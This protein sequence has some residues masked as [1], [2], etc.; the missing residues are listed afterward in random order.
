MSLEGPGAS[1]SPT[2]R[3]NTSSSSSSSSNNNGCKAERLVPYV[4]QNCLGI[5]EELLRLDSVE[6]YRLISE[7]SSSSSNI[8]SSSSGKRPCCASAL[9]GRTYTAGWP[10][11]PFARPLHFV[12]VPLDCPQAA[13]RGCLCTPAAAA[14]LTRVSSRQPAAAAAAAPAAPESSSSSYRCD[15]CGGWRYERFY[16]CYF[17]VDAG[18]LGTGAP[19]GAPRDVGAF[20]ASV[21]GSGVVACRA[22]VD[23]RPSSAR[24]APVGAL[25]PLREKAHWQG[26]LMVSPSFAYAADPSFAPYIHLKA[27][28][29]RLQVLLECLVHPLSF[30]PWPRCIYTSE[31]HDRDL[32]DGSRLAASA[33]ATAARAA[34]AAFLNRADALV[35]QGLCPRPAAA[36]A[37]AAAADSGA[38]ALQQQQQ[39]QQQ[40]KTWKE[41]VPN[42]RANHFL[43]WRVTDTAALVP[44][45]LLLAVV[46][47]AS[48]SSNSSSRRSVAD[49]LQADLQQTLLQLLPAMERLTAFEETQQQEQTLEQQQSLLMQQR[50]QEQQEAA[51][52]THEQASQQQQHQQHQHQ[53]QH[54]QHHHHHHQQRQPIRVKV[55]TAEVS[56][57]PKADVSR[58]VS[59]GENSPGVSLNR[60]TSISSSTGSS[61]STKE[62]RAAPTSPDQ[63][64]QKSFSPPQQQQKRERAV[65]QEQQEPQHQPPL[66]PVK[67][68]PEQKQ[69]GIVHKQ[70]Q[71]QQQQQQSRGVLLIGLSDDE[72]EDTTALLRRLQT[73][74]PPQLDERQ[75][76]RQQQQQSQVSNQKEKRESAQPQQ[77]QQEVLLSLEEQIL[78]KERRLQELQR[79]LQQ[80]EEQ[81]LLQAKQQQQQQRRE[82]TQQKRQRCLSSS[83]SDPDSSSSELGSKKTHKRRKGSLGRPLQRSSSSGSKRRG[84]SSDSSSDSE[85]GDRSPSKEEVA[86]I[87]FLSC[88]VSSCDTKRIDQKLQ[89]LAAKV[90]PCGL[91]QSSAGVVCPRAAGTGGPKAVGCPVRPEGWDSICFLVVPSQ[92]DPSKIKLQPRFLCA[93]L[94]EVFIIKEAAVDFILRHFRVWP[95]P[96][97]ATEAKLNKVFEE[98][99]FTDGGIPSLVMRQELAE[100]RLFACHEFYVCGNTKEA[101]LIRTLVKL[102]NGVLAPKGDNADYVVICEETLPEAQALRK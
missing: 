91:G 9:P 17:P 53:Q 62:P 75:Q 19:E 22:G 57:P 38:A 30:S 46:K 6:C 16:P 55:D 49:V 29:C 87:T 80:R 33:A 61:S 37:A 92:C 90:R 41:T 78:Q 27:A 68:E 71:Q 15:A 58:G 12:A 43:D 77:K 23:P 24:G 96:H 88:G 66:R 8:S 14:A 54:Q 28:R 97:T 45:R 5:P 60:E 82:K 83:S 72:E 39:Q 69:A 85:E 2:R 89:E 50:T 95:E 20:L 67:H 51:P 40:G 59:P 21:A 52:R 18:C 56:R 99:E 26:A 35:A 32:I 10:P 100:A 47:Q 34:V 3:D 31:Q 98:Q 25:G 70:Q 36:A 1:S 7:S 81:L 93:L 65:E 44:C 64:S 13:R 48:S 11:L 102:G 86:D 4:L 74:S 84:S 73:A 63:S 101:N 94:A 42:S 76:Q 79:E